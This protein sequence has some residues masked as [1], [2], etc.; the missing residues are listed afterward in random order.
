M[1]AH[2]WRDAAE[3]LGITV[4]APYELLNKA[5]DVAAVGVAW[6]ESFGSA[7]GTVVAGLRS[8][9]AIVQ[10]AARRQGKFCSFINEE[11]YERYDHDLFVATL[12][13]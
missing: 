8:D 6:I 1:V 7:Q 2:A 12:N 5:G 10:S 3:D 4:V 9:R 13:D 11:S